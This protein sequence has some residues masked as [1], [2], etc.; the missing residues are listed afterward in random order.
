MVQPKMRTATIPAAVNT[1]SRI[2]SV[3]PKTIAVHQNTDRLVHVSLPADAVKGTVI[4]DQIITPSIADRLRTQA[5]L[6]QKIRYSE[7]RF[8]IQTQ[9]A[10]SNSGGYVAAFL[11]DPQMD[12]GSGETA[13]RALSAVQG[14]VTSKFWQSTVM[15]VRATAQEYF[16]L[17]GNDVRLFSPG[18]LIVL[19]DGPPTTNVSITILMHWKVSLSRPAFQRLPVRLPQAVV[20][21]SFIYSDTQNL[22]YAN[23][24]PTNNTFNPTI[25][26]AGSEFLEN[27][28]SGLPPITAFGPNVLWYQL[29][30][31]IS[32]L[33]SAT[34]VRN[35]NF[36]SFRVVD[37][38]IVGR[39]ATL[40]SDENIE[41]AGGTDGTDRMIFQ[42]M[43]LTP[44]TS[45]EFS[46][47]TEGPFLVSVSPSV[48]VNR[49]PMISK[50]LLTIRPIESSPTLSKVD[51]IS[52]E[53]SQMPLTV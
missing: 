43:R 35:V 51:A 25:N 48:S 19:S 32:I 42:N 22:R 24:N 4:Y 39:L 47:T 44:V 41:W 49:Q 26:S 36:I 52:E 31:T 9:T 3:Q 33:T 11:H 27:A 16:T 28:I 8:E 30:T 12:I 20:I 13:L 53:L 14:T 6:F 10:T 2:K 23:W 21:A 15:T 18:R 5:A 7:L 45:S 37:G 34:R 29:P 40:P 1:A 50:E 46:G 38:H 17:N